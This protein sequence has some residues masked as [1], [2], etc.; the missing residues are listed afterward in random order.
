MRR[1]SVPHLTPLPLML[2]LAACGDAPLFGLSVTTPQGPDP[3]ADVDSLRLLVTDPAGQTTEAV[4]GGK[5]FGIELELQVSGEVGSVVLEGYLAQALV[6]RGETPPMVMR[7]AE[8]HATLLVARAGELSS[9]RPRLESAGPAMTAV[10]V[11]GDG[12]LLAGGEDLASKPLSSAALYDFIDHELREL[13]AMPAPRTDAVAAHCGSSCAVVATGADG[14]GLATQMLRFDGAAW[15]TFD[16]GLSPADRRRGAGVASLQDGSYLIV[17]GEGLAGAMNSTLVLDPGT[18]DGSPTLKVLPTR[19]GAT[20]AW[21]A[22][23]ASTGVV[24]AAGGQAGGQPSV[25]LFY[26]TSSTFQAVPLPGPRLAGAAAAVDL[27]DGRLVVVG[28]VD[29]DGVLLRDGWIIDPVTLAVIHRAS[30]LKQARAG[31]RVVRLGERLVVVGGRVEAGLADQAEVLSSD[32]AN[33]RQVS[34]GRPR[35]G[36]VVEQMSNGSFLMAGG[37]DAA[38][39]VDLLEVYQT[40]VAYGGG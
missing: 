4:K 28:G 18:S 11:P 32:L 39:P 40:S 17:G 8:G 19:A 34:V 31:H 33:L 25:E 35:Q 26:T 3:L 16:D 22:M 27:P 13:P 38:G 21:P 2:V 1:S 10:L 29:D 5:S 23:A 12:I 37:A 7:P 30:A 36:F 6:A 15:R 24:L 20:R 14:Q 9:L